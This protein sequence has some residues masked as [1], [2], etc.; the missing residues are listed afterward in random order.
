MLQLDL[1]FLISLLIRI[2]RC[3]TFLERILAIH[4]VN[5]SIEIKIS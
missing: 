5:F 1:E 2:V 3:Q 4:S